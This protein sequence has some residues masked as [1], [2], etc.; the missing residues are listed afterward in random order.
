MLTA[1][2]SGGC[3]G[4]NTY[5]GTI[6]GGSCQADIT[7]AALPSGNVGQSY[8]NYATALPVASYTYGV[9][10]GSLPPG[11]TLYAAIGLVIGYPTA[12]G[13]YSFTITAT[14]SNGCVGT[15]SYTV[16]IN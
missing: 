6:G 13:S 2:S 10:A 11:L 8:V 14:D 12:A 1:T 16:G 5:S 4:S 9:T 15:R 7:L 3:T